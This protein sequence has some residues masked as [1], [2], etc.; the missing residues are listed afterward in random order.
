MTENIASQPDRTEDS[1]I[2]PSIKRI[3]KNIGGRNL[4]AHENY[5]MIEMPSSPANQDHAQL[6][7][8]EPGNDA[9]QTPVVIIPKDATELLLEAME[10]RL[11]SPPRI[12]RSQHCV[13][14][15]LSSSLTLIHHLPQSLSDRSCRRNL[16]NVLRRSLRQRHRIRHQNLTES[17]PLKRLPAI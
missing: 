9:T 12:T 13:N 10:K 3:L 4:V 7:T 14:L 8:K 16:T 2:P 1:N 11:L 6:I 15:P 5:W 17:H